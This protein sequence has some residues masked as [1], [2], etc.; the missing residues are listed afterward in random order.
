MSNAVGDH[1]R[2]EIE[3]LEALT[4]EPDH[5]TAL[6]GL[7]DA[8]YFQGGRNEQAKVYYEAAIEKAT[9]TATFLTASNNLAYMLVE[10]QEY[11][12]ALH[13][14]DKAIGRDS[15]VPYLYKNKALALLGKGDLVN[16]TVAA[17]SAV[18]LAGGT[19]D[20][21][22]SILTVIKQQTGN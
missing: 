18:A 16:A 13:V 17:D 4:I 10:D 22:D 3:F 9:G 1:S 8:Y 2:A 11:A 19:Y 21:A 20:Q 12:R 7:A 5:E 6:L 14:L 15:K